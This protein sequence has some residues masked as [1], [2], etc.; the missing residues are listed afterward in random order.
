MAAAQAGRRLDLVLADCI[1]SVSRTQ[2]ARHIAEGAVGLNG[3]AAAPS[4]KVRAGDVIAWRPPA[5][6]Q[7][8]LVAEDIPL[9]VVYEDAHLLVVDKPAGLVV[10]PA[11]GHAAG[12]LVNALLARCR[13]LR[14]IGGELRPG[15]VHRIDKDTSGLLVVAKDDA[16]MNALGADFKVHR[17]RRVYEAL[18]VGR[19]ARASGRIDTL[20]GRDP[21]DRKKF[22]I[23]VKAG[24]RAVT[25]WRVLEEIGEAARLEA[26]LETGRTHQVRV[27]FAA[28]GCP[29][30]GDTTYGRPPRDRHVRAIGKQLG[31]QALHARVLGFHHPRSGQWMQFASP[32]PADFLAALAAL[33]ELAQ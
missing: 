33:R 8:E 1:G 18:V 14:G 16:T 15:I 11:A 26:E 30:L 23:K 28:M 2:L 7:V 22:S 3:R 32:P 13:D 31:R 17:V 27:H 6:R 5:V 10:H 20:H 21:R 24:K 19:P 25:N 12:T 9:R 29:L 4:Q